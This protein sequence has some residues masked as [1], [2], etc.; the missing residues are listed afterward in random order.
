M[1]QHGKRYRDAA[2]KID[3][4]QLYSPTAA[5]TLAVETA[6]VSYDA[7]IDLAL[8]LGID[9]RKADQMVR[10]SVALP[11]GTGKDMR[12]AVF[13]EGAKAAEAEEA[14]AD[15]V[16]S[17][18]VT[19]LIEAGTLD[20]DAVIAT[21]DQMGKIGRYG[22]VLGPRGLMPN[23]KTGTVTMDVAKAVGEIKAGKIEYRSDRQ[24]NVHLILG[25]GS[26][27]ARK[28][29]ENYGAVLD[30]LIRVKPASSKGRYLRSVHVSASMSPS[31]RIDPTRM[32]DL[33][34]EE[35]A[36]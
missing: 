11:N 8:R 35:P 2:A 16:G 30:E 19:A 23:P 3:R 34:E 36:A 9:P 10:G 17:A 28:L 14:G 13:A 22:K 24:A 29:V 4:D 6:T 21:P 1:A 5:M 25:K 20:F 15:I 33:W 7:T 18:E 26:F 32:R 27:G 12:V 31:V